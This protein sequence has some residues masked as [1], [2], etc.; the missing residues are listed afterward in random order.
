MIV[1]LTDRYFRLLKSIGKISFKFRLVYSRFAGHGYRRQYL[2][3]GGKSII[4]REIKKEIKAYCRERF[5]SAAYWPHLAYFTEMRGEF[6]KGWIPHD[7]FQHVLEPRLNPPAY[8]NLGDM[9]TSDHRRFGDFAIQPLFLFISGNFYNPNFERVDQGK[10]TEFLSHYNN[11]IVQKQE[12]G[13]GGK[14]VRVMHSSEFEPDRLKRGINY[15]IQPFIKQYKVLNDLYPDSVNTFRVITFLR[16]DGTVELKYALL[17]FGVN[18][19]KVDNLSSGGQCL[20]F[21]PDGR[22]SKIA[23]DTTGHQVGPTHINTGFRF[24]D[25]DI[26][27]FPE[28]IKK[29]INSHQQFPYIRL[30]G[31]DVCINEAGEPKL[32][33]WNTHRPSYTWEDALFGP[34]LTDDQELS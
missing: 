16:K 10:V 21:E 8:H 7:Y 23:Y 13:F 14:Q 29:C 22:P 28:I 34:F 12:F 33:E 5:G 24:E 15:I 26:P 2:R 4:T 11:C 30:V 17:R 19:I 1:Y 18:G 6:I 27:M 32:I 9:R 31:W 20:Y 25:L 3:K